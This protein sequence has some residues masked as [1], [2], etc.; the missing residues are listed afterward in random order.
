MPAD[1][2]PDGHQASKRLTALEVPKGVTLPEFPE[3][4]GSRAVPAM[5]WRRSH[6]IA[7]PYRSRRGAT[8]FGRASE[9]PRSC[10][11]LRR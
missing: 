7:G 3:H 8:R 11:R 10:L 1:E 4:F 6:L 2:A 5:T 9:A